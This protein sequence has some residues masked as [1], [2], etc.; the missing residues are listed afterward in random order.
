M[1]SVRDRADQ[2]LKTIFKLFIKRRKTAIVLV[3][4][5]MMGFTGL[6]A[7]NDNRSQKA[8]AA[9]APESC[10]TFNVGTRTITDYDENNILC[11]KNL[12]IP[13]QIS[14]TPVEVIGDDA[15]RYN[16]LTDI[17]IPNNVTLVGER[18]FMDNQLSVLSLPDSILSVGA[19]S[20]YRNQLSSIGFG[21]NITVIGGMAFGEN[22]ISG[23]ITLPGSVTTI[24]S[25][26]FVQNQIS[27]LTLPQSLITIGD[28]AFGYNQLS[29]IVIPDSVT[30]LGQ[31]AFAFNKL[32]SVKLSNS[33]TTIERLVFAYNQ[34]KSIAI[35]NSVISIDPTAFAIQTTIFYKDIVDAPTPEEQQALMQQFADNIFY[36]QLLLADQSNQNNF[37]D[38]LI[39]ESD[40]FFGGPAGDINNDGDQ[41]DP[42]GGHIV[43][44][45]YVVITYKD[46]NGNTLSPA[47]T[48]TGNGLHSYLVVDNPNTDFGLYYR[49]GNQVTFSPLAIDGYVT[50][51][52]QTVTFVLGENQI[53]FVYAAV[54]DTPSNPPVAPTN[55][56][57][58][59]PKNPDELSN[60]GKNIR[61][62]TLVA[63]SL[64]A[65]TSLLYLGSRRHRIIYVCMD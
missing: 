15:F 49:A 32:S 28:G 17:V 63:L 33:L 4:A 64:V 14:G 57:S 43:N 24:E 41:S 59:P 5:V 60:T 52:S 18:A 51:S 31:Y 19:N 7:I 36:V 62:T 30:T 20:F 34:L 26:A 47:V 16:H 39:I 54:T 65:V 45:A 25:N 61:I 53:N 37:T 40:N 10:F 50:P 11:P 27:N 44:S 8:F 29:N 21:N 58:R 23:T 48:F 2:T 3:L 42:V 35:P 6:V 46:A 55:P 22:Q 56:N 9:L 13:S 38:S 12:E 1:Y